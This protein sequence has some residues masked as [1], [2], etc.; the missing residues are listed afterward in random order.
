MFPEVM[1]SSGSGLEE[2]LR[3]SAVAVT[4]CSTV[5]LDCLRLGIPIISFKWHDF[6]YKSLLESHSVFNFAQSLAE[7]EQLVGK[8]L[9]GELP[10]LDS[11]HQFVAPTESSS[12]ADFFEKVPK[13]R[14]IS[15]IKR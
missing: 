4:Y 7:L 8:G 6:S 13:V 14:D 9:R 3:S 11:Y 2:V 12:L 1:F 15:E 5:F 10:V